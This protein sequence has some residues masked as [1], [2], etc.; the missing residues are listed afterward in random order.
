MSATSKIEWT[1]ATF[2]PWRGCTK[3][4]PGCEN[5]YAEA[6]SKRNPNVLGVW[7]N[8][9]NRVIAS[10]A[11]WREPVKWNRQAYEAGEQRRVF[12]ASLADVFED[13]EELDEPRQRLFDLILAT[14]NL[15]WLLLT[16]RPDFMR[17]WL[18]GRTFMGER[19]GLAHEWGTGWTNV[20][21]G[22]SVEDSKR[23]SRI[24]DLLSVPAVVHFL[25]IE[26]LLGPVDI[27]DYI[28]QYHGN[29]PKKWPYGPVRWVIVGGE[30]GH[31]ARPIHPAWVRSLRD[32]CQSSGTPFFFKQWG[33]FGPDQLA[34]TRF[35][36]VPSGV[37]MDEPASMFRVGKHS[38]GRLLD[39]REWSEF[40]RI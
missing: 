11:Y 17:E 19:N 31:H 39:G 21:L 8:N 29:P 25:S 33:E 13:R 7:G 12:C 4:S 9:G 40:P 37:P 38:A 2:N 35:T 15:D 24:K 32:Q 18:T 14:P 26:P 10:D 30:S 34:E 36:P 1:H 20:W 6:M 5:C 28:H 16:K 23:R 3:V 27:E 22:T